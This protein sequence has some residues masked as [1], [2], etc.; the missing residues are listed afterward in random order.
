[1]LRGHSFNNKDAASSVKVAIVNEEFAKRYLKGLDPL[2]Q[3]LSIEEIIPGLPKLVQR[4]NGRSS[5]SSTMSGT[6]I[7]ATTIPD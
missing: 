5:V 7:F 4:W 3:R 1:M 6:G 2:Q